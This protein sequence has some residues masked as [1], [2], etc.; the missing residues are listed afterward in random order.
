MWVSAG[1]GVIGL[2]SSLFG[3]SS[4]NSA[5]RAR[6][7]E[8]Q[9]QYERQEDWNAAQ[10]AYGEIQS[11]VSHAWDMAKHEA[12]KFQE[13]E[14][15]LYYEF[16]QDQQLD[17]AIKN[18]ELNTD[19]LYDQYVTGENLRARQ[20]SLDLG[21]TTSRNILATSQNRL[22]T[23]RNTTQ[24]KE[25]GLKA[26]DLESQAQLNKIQSQTQ[27][28]DYLISARENANSQNQ[29]MLQQQQETQAML[30]SIATDIMVEK[31]E[32]DITRI[33]QQV[34]EGQVRS[35]ATVRTG[36]TSTARQL[37]M[38]SAK[39]LGRTYGQLKINQDKRNQQVIA[40]NLQNKGTA[41]Q[42]YSASLKTSRLHLR[43][44]EVAEVADIRQ[45]QLKNQ[46]EGVQLASAQTNAEQQFVNAQQDLVNAEQ[47][48]AFDVFE[49]LTIPGFELAQKQGQREKSALELN[50]MAAMTEASMP[51]RDAIMFEPQRALPGLRPY[52]AGPTI[53]RTESVGATIGGAVLGA[54][55]GFLSGSYKNAGG[56]LSFL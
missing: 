47:Q 48:Y 35:R 46:F 36:G 14:N 55:Q 23:S 52:G 25:Q 31:F 6:N 32:Q 38:N 27:I 13:A 19:A 49:D 21:L 12:L 17:Y 40:Q 7:K 5:T 50:T 20:E 2:A 4:R 44:D 56:G 53:E 30:A 34:E 16:A 43:G 28:K 18:L 24:L 41:M 8:R 51:Y 54:A 29:L 1:L 37:A 45:Q 42:M 22:A 3:S 9:E 39:A 11:D 10:Y 15:K 33:A 26:N